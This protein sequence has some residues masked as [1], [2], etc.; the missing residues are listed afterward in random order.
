[1][2]AFTESVVEQAVLA[3]DLGN[4]Y[5]ALTEIIPQTRTHGASVATRSI[6]SP[7]PCNC[8]RNASESL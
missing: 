8:R 4:A 2:V 5:W 1:M 6:T 3:G 7:A